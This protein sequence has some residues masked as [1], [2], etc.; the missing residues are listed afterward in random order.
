MDAWADGLNYYLYK[1]PEVKPRVIT[2]F[3]PWMALTLQRGQHRRRHRAREPRASSRR[4]TAKPVTQNPRRGRAA[5]AERRRRRLRRAD[6]IERHRH[7]AV[8]H[9]VDTTRCSGSTRTRRSSSASEL[10][11]TSDEGLERLRRRDVG[12]VLRLPGLQRARRLDAHVERRRQHRRVPRDGHAR[13]AAASTTG[14][15]AKSGR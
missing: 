11:M 2:H 13:R 7:R 3:E 9:G 10:Q 12:P 14:T 4:S 8:E 6:R 15:A 5:S 1:H